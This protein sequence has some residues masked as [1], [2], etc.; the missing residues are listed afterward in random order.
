M[1]T[2]E[3]SCFSFTSSLVHKLIYIYI[4]IYL[5]IFISLLEKQEVIEYFK[6]WKP[7]DSSPFHKHRDGKGRIFIIGN[8]PGK[9]PQR[10]FNSCFKT[11][12]HVKHV[13]IKLQPLFW[14]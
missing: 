12:K 8:R 2:F 14:P 7:K 9:N 5:Y 3:F 6:R 10:Q 4:Y 1:K 11:N 13:G